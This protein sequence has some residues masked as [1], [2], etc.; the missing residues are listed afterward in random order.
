MREKIKL[1]F[2]NIKMKYHSCRKNSEL[3][4]SFTNSAGISNCSATW[5]TNAYKCKV[6]G[7]RWE[8]D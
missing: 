3:I 7:K 2:S 1:F 6:C 4:D 5:T 8:V